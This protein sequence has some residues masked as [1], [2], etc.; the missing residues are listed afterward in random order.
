MG[1]VFPNAQLF[2]CFLHLV[3]NMKKQLH[4]VSLAT[5]YNN[6]ADYILEARMIVTL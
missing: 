1:E 5:H 3:K 6:E 2:G 4:E